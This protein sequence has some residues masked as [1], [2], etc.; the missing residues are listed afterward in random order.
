MTDSFHYFHLVISVLMTL[1]RTVT[2]SVVK[3]ILKKHSNANTKYL[4]SATAL[5]RGNIKVSV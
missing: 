4:E 3:T 2:L 1:A 5:N